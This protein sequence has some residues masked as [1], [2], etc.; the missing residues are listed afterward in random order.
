MVSMPQMGRIGS[1]GE[2][3]G[4]FG[5]RGIIAAAILPLAPDRNRMDN[6]NL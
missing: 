6:K 1:R 3:A 4:E 5:T 2:K